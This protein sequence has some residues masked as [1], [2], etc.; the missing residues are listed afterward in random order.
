MNKFVCFLFFL[1]LNPIVFSQTYIYQ[2][3][4]KGKVIGKL[5]ATS[6]STKTMKTYKVE[7]SV[8]LPMNSTYSYTLESIYEKGIL[9]SSEVATFLNGKAHRVMST[10]QD[11]DQL[12]FIK[13]D[14]Q[15]EILSVIRYSEAK[16][17]GEKPLSFDHIYSEFS[18]LQ[19]KVIKVD[20]NTY[21]TIHPKSGNKSVYE[22]QNE[23]LNQATVDFGIFTFSLVRLQ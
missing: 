9:V 13:G 1:C 3:K 22:Y 23:I 11:G 17:Y 12:C 8:Q 4:N 15:E 5:T 20:K 19:K 7:S 18:G 10:V 14:E 16:I 2:V 6:S 21:E